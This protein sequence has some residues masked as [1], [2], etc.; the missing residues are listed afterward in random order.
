MWFLQNSE[1]LSGFQPRDSYKKN[2]YEKE[3]V[4]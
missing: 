1:F 2:S 4:Y 3:M